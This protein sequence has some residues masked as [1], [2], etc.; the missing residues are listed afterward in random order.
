MAETAD[1][2]RVRDRLRF[3]TPFWARNCATILTEERIPVRLDARPWQLQFDAALEKQRRAGQPMRAIILKARKLG[4]STWVQ[5]RFLQRVTQMPN[6]YALVAA[7]DRKTAGVLMDMARYMYEHLPTE[8]ELGIGCSIKPQIVGQGQSRG[9]GGRWMSFGDRRRPHEASVYETL[10]AGATAS[11]RG[12]TPDM[13]HGSEVAHYDDANFLVGALSAVPQRPETQIILESTAN[14]FNAFHDMWQRAVAG[15]E[16]EDLGGYYVPLFFGWQ[17]NPFNAR[18]FISVQARDRFER[19]LGDPDGGGDEEELL[20]RESFGVTLEQLF[21]RRT[22]LNAVPFDGNV[23]KF[24][25]EHPATPEQAF[26]GSGQPVFSGVLVA[27]ALKAAGSAER[28][29]EGVLR[30]DDMRT[31]V[32]KGRTVEVP[33]TALWLPEAEP[34][35]LD[36]WDRSKLLVWEH[37][38]NAVSQQGLQGH[39]RRPDGQYVIFADVAMGSGNTDGDGDH[40]AVQVLD[41]VSRM[42]VARYRS[43]IALHDLP[44]V[45]C[46]IGLYY[47]E[48]WLAVEVNGPGIAVV[49]ALRIEYRY[50]RLYRRR[51]RGDSLVD[52]PQGSLVGWQTTIST[53]PLLEQTFGQVLKDGDHGLRDVATGRE[54]TTY[55]EDPK[56]PAKHGAQKGAHDDLAI[57]FMGAHRVAAELRPRDAGP[58]RSSTGRTVRDDLTGY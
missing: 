11:G 57:S 58:V 42:Q 50:R 47:N 24:H 5:A 29:V 43:R 21:W 46:L 9:S 56:N 16:D 52:A 7:Q 55:V 25:Q 45:L 4:F 20:F 17:D 49:D 18:Q 39:E 48:A 30:G 38:V 1:D 26:I 19:T 44:L 32:L 23:E 51:T 31:R 14:G 12:Y 2:V 36:L 15:A 10:T 53:K 13:F 33:Q 40:H 8:E 35:D 54:F 27:R 22:V 34:R 3:D 6:R 41:H 28:P 37:P